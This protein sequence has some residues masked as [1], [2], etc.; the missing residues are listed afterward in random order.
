MSRVTHPSNVT[1]VMCDPFM[2][3]QR[4]LEG[5]TYYEFEF[6]ATNP[7]YTR[8]QLAVVAAANGAAAAAAGA[9][10]GWRQHGGRSSSGSGVAAAVGAAGAAASAAAGWQK[11]RQDGGSGRD[12]VAA[13]G[14]RQQ[15]Q[16]TG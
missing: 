10:A 16:R 6:V 8:H 11:Q 13:A 1:R 9:G 7:R 2:S 3:S 15:Q 12:R 4:E 5:H 14:W